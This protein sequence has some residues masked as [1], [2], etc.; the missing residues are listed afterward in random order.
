MRRGL[1]RAAR[2]GGFGVVVGAIGC[3]AGCAALA[4][5]VP[6]LAVV[7]TALERSDETGD[8]GWE[9][10]A[11]VHLLGAL[12][13]PGVTTARAHQAPRAPVPWR[14]WPCRLPAVC[15]WEARARREALAR[16]RQL[17]EIDR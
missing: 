9:W 2:A 3:G 14:P 12:D 6:D 10:G 15:A 17:A 1:R 8:H 13:P 7:G 4:R 16:G 11:S 5:A